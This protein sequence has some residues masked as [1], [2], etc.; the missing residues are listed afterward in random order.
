MG[1]FHRGGAEQEHGGARNVEVYGEEVARVK[2]WENVG[3]T[4]EILSMVFGKED[5]IE[6]SEGMGDTM[7]GSWQ[8]RWH[9]GRCV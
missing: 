3:G 1:E 5:G 2:G 7:D 8:H 4:G 9:Y 6:L